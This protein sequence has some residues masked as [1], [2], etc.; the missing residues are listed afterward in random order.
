MGGGEGLDD[1]DDDGID[2]DKDEGKSDIRSSPTLLF[3]AC[4]VY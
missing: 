3:H 1:D 2:V 4:N